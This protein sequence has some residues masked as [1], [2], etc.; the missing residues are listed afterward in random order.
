MPSAACAALASGSVGAVIHAE[1]VSATYRS[2]DQRAGIQKEDR[3]LPFPPHFDDGLGKWFAFHD[4]LAPVG[5]SRLGKCGMSSRFLR[6]GNT[7]KLS[8]M[9][10]NYPKQLL[11]PASQVDQ[12]EGGNARQ[13]GLL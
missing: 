1:P 9:T 2:F 11:P 6:V 3:H 8:Q 12:N 13:S 10:S 4:Q 7:T 5:G